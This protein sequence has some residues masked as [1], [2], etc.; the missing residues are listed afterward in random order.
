MVLGDQDFVEKLKGM[1]I[2]GGVKGDAKAQPWYRMIQSIDAET[3]IN[4]QPIISG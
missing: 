1:G 3:L 2:K 4:K